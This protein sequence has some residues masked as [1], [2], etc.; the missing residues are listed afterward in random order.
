MCGIAGI[1]NKNG[2][3]VSRDVLI[4]MRDTM[5][6][7]GPDDAGIWMDGAIGLAHRRFSILDPSPA[8]QLTDTSRNM[9]GIGS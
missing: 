1:L 8:G 7:R 6:H 2:A 4:A 5:S 3:S 9:L